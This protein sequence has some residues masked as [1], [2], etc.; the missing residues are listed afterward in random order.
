MTDKEAAAGGPASGAEAALA[1]YE[2]QLS[3]SV[4]AALRMLLITKSASRIVLEPSNEEDLQADIDD[5]GP[6]RVEPSA[7]LANGHKLVVQVKYTSGDPW[8]LA[9]FKALLKHGKRRK[10]AIE[11]LGDASVHYLLVTNADATG[12]AR[13]LLVD[14][15]EETSDPS[16]LP[17]SLRKVLKTSPEGRVAIWGGLAARRLE[18]ELAEILNKTLRIPLSN[19]EACLNDL[20]K[21]AKRRMRGAVAGVWTREDLQGTV[22]VHGGYLASAIELEA[23]VPPLNFANMKA[24]LRDRNAIIIKGPS[25]TGKTL[26]AVALCDAARQQ[27]GRLDV[28]VVGADSDPS[29]TLRPID[30]GPKLFY[31]EDPWG[32]FSLRSGSEAW[33]AQLPKLLGRAHPGHRYVVTSRS[34]M[35]GQANA[36]KPLEKWSIEL[37][38]DHYQGGEFAKI[39]DKRMHLLAVHLQPFA[40]EFRSEALEKLQTPL[41]LDLFFTNL[42]DGPSDGETQDDFLR[43]LLGLAH[44]DAVEQVV[45]NYLKSIDS[46]GIASMLWGLLLARGQFERS[47]LTAIQGRVRKIE[48][49]GGLGKL[50]DRLIATRHLRQPATAVSLAHPSVRAGLEEFV[51]NNWDDQVNALEHLIV[52]LTD[53]PGEHHEWGLESAGRVLHVARQ[54]QQGIENAVELEISISALQAIDAWLEEALLHPPSDFVSLIQLAA[55]IGSKDSNLSELARW[56]M[57]GT[58]RGAAYFID[59]W[60]PAEF[61]GQWYDRISSDPRSRLVAGRF[62][63]EVLP[64]D[65]GDYGRRFVQQLDRISSDLTPDYLAAARSVVGMGHEPNTHAISVGAVRDLNAFE[66][67]MLEAVSYLEAMESRSGREE[68]PTWRQ[69]E[70]GET[71]KAFEEYYGSYENDD[72]AASE[73]LVDAYVDAMRA[74]GRWPELRAHPKVAGLTSSWC[75]AV[76]NS[77]KSVA[78]DEVEALLDATRGS[79]QEPSAWYA[80]QRHW[81]ASLEKRLTA[82]LLS[83]GDD[84]D[85][86]ASLVECAAVHSPSSFKR[87]LE[88][89]S[90]GDPLQFVCLMIDLHDVADFSGADTS[91][92]ACSLIETLGP[93][94]GELQKALLSEAPPSVGPEVLSLLIEA[95]RVAEPKVLSRLLPIFLENGPTAIDVIRRLFAETEDRDL[96]CRAAEA[97]VALDDDELIGLALRHPRAD[98][99]QTALEHRLSQCNGIVP[100]DLLAFATDR[101]SRVRRA[102]VDKVSLWPHPSHIEALLKLSNDRWS[103]AEPHYEDTESYPIARVAVEALLRY[104]TLD[105]AVGTG[106]VGLAVDTT[107]NSLARIAFKVAA[108]RCGLAVRQSILDVSNDQTLTWTRVHALQGLTAAS[109]V[110]QQLL[111]RLPNK[112]ILSVAPPLAVAGIELLCTHLSVAEAASRLEAISHSNNRRALILVGAHALKSRDETAA[113]GVLDMLEP[114]HPARQFFTGAPLPRSIL[115]DLGTVRV[116]RFVEKFLSEYWINERTR[117][118]N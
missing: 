61:D 12:E 32:Q 66:S 5:P 100:A 53:L 36:T 77:P 102:L 95:S 85:L 1:G 59:D 98:A 108:A 80:A 43:R 34:D 37:D 72:G 113:I 11:H 26:A 65:R 33:T 87:A 81:H 109:V 56:F 28:V 54:F 70:D 71:D 8:S 91:G 62:I 25:G 90:D 15:F 10:P 94:A 7:S 47:H 101:G 3:V 67:V 6:G 31:V 30:T 73:R 79:G 83:V 78:I 42:S 82:A 40:L 75:R 118:A 117:A 50:V 38:A 107:D 4:L 68:P 106:L 18:L 46:N 45:E 44:R 20:Q 13:S 112:W 104:E 103:D 84:Q 48:G 105:D 35:L 17:A 16:A 21:E 52:V 99:R 14:D 55:D 89:A 92:S 74:P 2:Y 111:D 69:I 110:E 51:K 96:A 93:K 116:R 58:R 97:A 88:R 64:T 60:K 22:R 115:N 114:G 86:R 23:F 49:F 19:H 29:S 76:R 41:E 63:R 57:N 24:A 9:K 27:D 39:Y